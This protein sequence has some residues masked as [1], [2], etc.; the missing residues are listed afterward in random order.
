[1]AP[2]REAVLPAA[3]R[4]FVDRDAPQR[5]FEEAAFSIPADHRRTCPSIHCGPCRQ[6]PILRS[7][8]HITYGGHWPFGGSAMDAK[9]LEIVGQ[10]AGIGG[11][12]LGVL[13]I[14]FRDI[15]R[16][17]IFPKLP[18]E[19]AYRLLRLI[20]G[21]VWSVAVIGIMAWVYVSMGPRS[22][23][24]KDG[25]VAI[26]GDANGAHIQTTR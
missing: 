25:G 6:R 11:V 24:A 5:I 22:V 9:L 21:A 4:V 26:G 14:V 2:P 13:L 8:V 10:T 20:T 3:N 7:H 15:I 23:T 12:A 17:N 1:M 16:K 18:P 19:Q